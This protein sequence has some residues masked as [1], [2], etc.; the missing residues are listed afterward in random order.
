MIVLELTSSLAIAAG[1]SGAAD[2]GWSVPGWVTALASGV[3]LLLGSSVVAATLGALRA[4]AAERRREYTAAARSLTSW[5]EY[6]YRIRRKT[7]LTPEVLAALADHGHTLQETLADRSA[8]CAAEHELLG[9]V[10]EH[11]RAQL[12]LAVGP[13]IEEAWKADPVTNGEGML[14]GSSFV[15]GADTTK[16]RACFSDCVRERFGWRRYRPGLHERLRSHVARHGLG[17]LA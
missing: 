1:K 6:P 10:F 16:L 15:V 8:W 14:L 2:Q 3:L 4:S 7:S 11:L 12:S 5:A 9:R 13:A 17:A